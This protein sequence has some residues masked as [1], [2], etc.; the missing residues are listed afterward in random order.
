[1]A[2]LVRDPPEAAEL[3][4]GAVLRAG[5]DAEA[6]RSS[7]SG[8]RAVAR[9][10]ELVGERLEPLL[11]RAE[12]QL[13]L[14]GARRVAVQLVLDHVARAADHVGAEQRGEPRAQ[15]R[16]ARPGGARAARERAPRQPHVLQADGALPVLA[17]GLLRPDAHAG[18]AGRDEYGRHA[19]SVARGDQEGVGGD[20][21]EDVTLLALEAEDLAAP[22][23][24]G[25]EGGGIGARALL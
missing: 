4:D 17:E 2:A 5:V 18:R 3:G 22:A 11:G 13:G 24:Q 12:A 14:L 8:T 7:L 6:H 15:R 10:P 23:H 21:L 20:A 9:E 25:R 1:K 16:E 19:L